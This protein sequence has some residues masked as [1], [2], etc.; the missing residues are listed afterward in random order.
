MSDVER[1]LS[2]S[3]IKLRSPAQRL[4]G[5]LA[6]TCAGG[7][8]NWYRRRVREEGLAFTSISEARKR[9]KE[10]VRVP[11]CIGI[12]GPTQSFIIRVSSPRLLREPVIVIQLPASLSGMGAHQG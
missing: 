12:D 7:L 10:N 1:T 6:G 11:D 5:S 8:C 2:F 4:G 3:A 9:V